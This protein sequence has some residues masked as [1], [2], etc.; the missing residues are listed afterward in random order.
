MKKKREKK[1]LTISE[2]H[3]LEP[4]AEVYELSPFRK[5][6]VVIK[7][8]PLIGIDKN[9]ALI[10]AREVARVLIAAEIPCHIIVG[11]D[12]DVKFLEIK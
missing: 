10:T 7:K 8:S 6:I 12:D 5:Y 11:T 1:Q 4:K 9:R 2:I 3:E